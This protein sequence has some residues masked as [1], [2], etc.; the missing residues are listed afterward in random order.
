MRPEIYKQYDDDWRWLPYPGSGSYLDDSG[1]G[2]LAVYHA[3]IELE[4]YKD[5]TVPQCRDYMVQFATVK[6][7]TLWDGI[8][9]GLEHYGYNVHWR[10]ADDMD[11][12]FRELKSSLNSGVILFAKKDAW[13]Y[14]PDGTLW[15]KTGHYI[16]FGDYEIRSDGTHW[17]YLKDSGQRDHDGWICFEKSMKGCCRNVWICKSAKDAPAPTPTPTPDDGHYHGL[18]P[19]VRLYLEPGDRGENVTRLQKYVDWYFDGAFF[20]ACGPADGVYGKNTLKWVNKMLTDFFGAAEADGLVGPKTIARMK[21]YSKKAPKPEPTPSLNGIVLDVSD[22]QDDIDWA[23]AKASGVAGVI[24]RCGLRG[25]EKGDLRQDSMFLEHITAAH[26]AGLKVGVYMF[27]TAINAAE[28]REEAVFALNQIKKAGLPMSYP[29]AIDTENVFWEGGGKGRANEDKLSAEKRTE[30]VRAFHEEMKTNGYD[31]MTY[32]S[33]SWFRNC[34]DMSKLPYKVWV[35]Q[36]NETCHYEGEKALWQYTSEGRISGY[37]GVVDMSKNYLPDNY[38]PRI[39]PTPTPTP[40]PDPKP[41]SGLYPTAAE[42]K[43]ASNIGIHRRMCIWGRKIAADDRYRYVYFDEP[44]GEECAICHPHGGKNEGWQCI[45]LGAA[46]WHHG[47]CI[48]TACHCGVVWQGRGS[49]LDLYEASTD[50][51]ALAL[52]QKHFGV[53]DLQII[54][55]RNGIPKAQW[56]MG[57]YCCQI[58]NGNVFQHVFVYLGGGEI[59][60]ASSQHA[61]KRKDIAVRSYS[62]YSAKVIVRYTGG[63]TYIQKYDEGT[64]VL[65]WQDFLNWWSDGQFYKECG[66]GDG[67]FGENTHKWSVKF[68][69]EVMGKGQG[70]GTVGPKTIAAAQSVRK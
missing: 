17:F 29:I 31:S 57:D 11:D 37:G 42:I 36:Y 13:S 40:T 7:G 15:T 23:K 70:D 3:A 47:G 6:N 18:Y 49:T 50:A 33:L 2:C 45:G 54:R 10:E 53:K 26:K 12:I 14:G 55:N 65:K 25:G 22:F 68:Q 16:Y 48:P 1:C 39:K 21:E 9:K 46:V 27:T 30:A 52:A 41:Y 69:E 19:A 24:V 38:D 66:A 64:A 35:A 61:D 43:A 20:K 60:D 8:T 62:G 56:Q 32:A 44:Y 51:Q 67:I 34:L 58:I 5:L 59:V 28:G 4:P 63:F